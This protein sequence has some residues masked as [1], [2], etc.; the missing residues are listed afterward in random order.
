MRVT[1]LQCSL[2]ASVNQAAFCF[3]AS[4]LGFTNLLF[5]STVKP[6]L[7]LKLCSQIVSM[8]KM[9]PGAPTHLPLSLALLLLLLPSLPLCPV[10]RWPKYKNGDVDGL[11]QPKGH[12]F[13]TRSKVSDRPWIWVP[14]LD[15]SKMLLEKGIIHLKHSSGHL[16]HNHDYHFR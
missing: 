15:E 7:K 5:L 2:Q 16:D 12:L 13:K 10:S 3:A 9:I 11:P 6:S 8:I 1:L 14:K 4:S